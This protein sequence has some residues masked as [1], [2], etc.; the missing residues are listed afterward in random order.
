M[1][2]Y[3]AARDE[4][5]EVRLGQYGAAAVLEINIELLAEEDPGREMSS[6]PGS[7]HC[8]PG[9]PEKPK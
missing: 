3:V 6:L 5:I 7:V 1:Q 8:R 2:K 4:A 9:S